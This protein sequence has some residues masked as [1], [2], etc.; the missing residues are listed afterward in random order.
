MEL[1]IADS[2]DFGD[3]T[4]IEG[5]PTEKPASAPLTI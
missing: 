5:K 1:A 4:D 2:S 3:T